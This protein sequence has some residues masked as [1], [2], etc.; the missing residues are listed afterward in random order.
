MNRK[1]ILEIIDLFKNVAP[2]KDDTALEKIAKGSSFIFRGMDIISN[3]KSSNKLDKLRLADS[4]ILKSIVFDKKISRLVKTKNRFM[5]GGEWS[6]KHY[7]TKSVADCGD[8]VFIDDPRSDASKV[9]NFY[10][11]K[12]N[13]SKLG[14]IVYE[15][16]S[17]K[18]LLSSFYDKVNYGDYYSNFNVT[19]KFTPCETTDKILNNKYIIEANKIIENPGT[20][21]FYGPPG[22][23]K[24]TFI[25]SEKYLRSKCIRIDS[26][27]F[28]RLDDEEFNQLV[29]IFKPD[30]LLVEEIDKNQNKLGE[31]LLKL[32][33][34]RRHNMRIIITANEISNMNP[35]LLRPQRIDHI[36]NFNLPDEEEIKDMVDHYCKS[37]DKEEI[38]KFI[39]L[40]V[41]SKLSHA[42]VVDFSKKLNNNYNDI[43][44]YVNFIKSIGK[45]EEKAK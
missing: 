33:M 18:I 15:T 37:Q 11:G 44:N 32:E 17:N 25:F 16:Y 28:F 2:S 21:L 40:M 24:S 41:E 39:K 35:A 31:L 36:L 20:Y 6:R 38:D 19:Y 29:S 22:T 27:D 26:S 42:Y 4:K 13:Y 3:L 7:I 34:V 5:S 23:G 10:M 30:I 14:E 45:K 43:Y 1:N 8:L 9:A 12:F